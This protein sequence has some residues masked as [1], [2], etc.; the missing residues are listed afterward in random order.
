LGLITNIELNK[1]AKNMIPKMSPIRLSCVVAAALAAATVSSQAQSATATISWV[2]DVDGSDYDYTITLQNTGSVDLNGFWYGWT[3]GGNNL[4][5][6]PSSADNSLGWE[7]DLSGNSIM[8]ENAYSENG[9]TY[10]YGT[11]L[12]PGASATF[13]FVSSSSPTDIMNSPSGESVAYVSTIDFSQG[14]DGDSTSVFSPTS[15]A[16]P[17]AVPTVTATITGVANGGSYNYTLTLQNTGSSALNSLWYGWTTS[18]NN[19]PANPSNAGNSLGWANDLDGNSIM[20]VNSSGTALAAGASAT[21]TFTSSSSPSAITTTPSGESVAYVGGID[22]SQDA[23]GDSTAAFSP[24]LVAPPPAVPTVTA[25]ITGVAN[26]GSYNYT[27]TLQNTGNSALNS[28]WY[29]WTTGGNNLPANPSNAANSLG[30]ANDLDGNSIMWVNSSGTAL[31]AGASATFTFTSSSSPSAITATPSGKSVA[32]VGGIDFTQDVAGDSTQPFSPTL[33]IPPTPTVSITNPASGTT[34]TAPASVTI[35]ASPS[36]SSGTVTNVAFFAGTNLLGSAQT[37][38]FN[39][40][41]SNLTAGSYSLTAVAT[42]AGVS[43]TSAVVN[44]T[45]NPPAPPTPT[46]SITGPTNGATFTAP[47]SV[48]ITTS[49]SVSGGTV[50]NVA[51]FAGASLLGS[52]QTSPFNLTASNLAAGSYSLTVVATAAGISA[53][54]S[55][56]SIT[57]NPPT[58]TVTATISGVANGGSYNYTITLKNTG[59]SALNS[60]W[61]GWTTGGNN[62]PSNPSNAG[63]S[64]GWANDLDGNSI[65]WVNSSGTALA[66]GA[67]TTFTFVSSSSPS[68]ITASPSGESVA[69]I[70]AIDFTEGTAGDST[71]PFSPT[72]VN[73]PTPTVTIT[74]PASGSVFAAP[75]TVTLGA[76]ASVTNGTVTNVAFFTNG[77]LAGS[78]TVSPFI[79]TANNLSAKSYALTAVA[80]AAGLSATSAV[81]NISVVAPVVIS[82][83]APAVTA[84][85]FSFGYSVNPGLTYI[86]ET[87]SNLVNWVPIAT[88]IP[89][90]NPATFTDNSGMSNYLFYEVVLS[91]NP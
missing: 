58:P 67:S 14:V 79:I 81:V 75:A 30:W 13:T 82:N 89:S 26:G 17:P 9:Y 52:A 21:F 51:F 90:S 73:P 69:Y 86:I 65:M 80:T 15:T 74:N 60:F 11:P 1:S 40:T 8:W 83:T 12:A 64:L 5:S 38:P 47:A 87:S 61:Y 25:T 32:Y 76:S 50:T 22:F 72:L 44:I 71:Q 19:L 37:A 23:A 34:F 27:V 31:A 33:V 57:V 42:A 16:P 63:N 88:N 48:P 10:Y 70:G 56:V 28:F 41:A 59:N 53:T 84:G 45:V 54:S 20:W 39:L 91:P 18:G 7:N 66:P 3:Q 2:A 4:P 68:A 62:L 36:V 29:G 85:H 6:S 43:A 24:T 55:V 35:K 78:A 77:V 46:V 49:A